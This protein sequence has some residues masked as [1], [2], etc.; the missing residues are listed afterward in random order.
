MKKVLSLLV[1]VIAMSMAFVML[2][3]TNTFA[4]P[5]DLVNSTESVAT[6]TLTKTEGTDHFT[7][8][9]TNV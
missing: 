8:E 3:T 1:A 5:I 4:T 2:F 6:D 7:D 9:D